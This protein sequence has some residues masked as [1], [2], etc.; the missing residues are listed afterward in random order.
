MTQL[1]PLVVQSLQLAPRTPQVLSL[2]FLQEP[3]SQQPPAQLIALHL[4]PPPPLEPDDPDPEEPLPEELPDV[5]PEALP[6]DDP[7]A[8]PLEDPEELPL[9]DPEPDP[10]EAPDD[11]GVPAQ[12]LLWQVWPVAVQSAQVAPSVPQAESSRPVVQFPLGS[13][14]PRQ[15]A[16]QPVGD[17]SSP[18][19][20]DEGAASSPAGAPL[21]LP[22]PSSPVVPEL[23]PLADVSPEPAL[24]PLEPM[25][26]EPEAPASLCCCDVTTGGT[27]PSSVAPVAQAPTRP[28]T[29]AP[30]PRRSPR[31]PSSFFC[32]ALMPDPFLCLRPRRLSAGY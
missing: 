18:A 19:S 22:E 24:L 8:L 11:V 15:M 16:A 10:E 1:F 6:L 2:I 13:Q 29:I 26:D 17:A 20:S 4:L 7:E 12:A 32:L 21:L 5:L 28:S 9:E 27:Y 30:T 14:H 31:L 3:L 25:D 23:S